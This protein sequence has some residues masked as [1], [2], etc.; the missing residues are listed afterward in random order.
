MTPENRSEQPVSK[1]IEPEVAS[2]INFHERILTAYGYTK[3]AFFP[4]DMWNIRKT[5]TEGPPLLRSKDI[6]QKLG[7]RMDYLETASY[8]PDVLSGF[9]Y[10]SEPYLLED[11]ANNQKKT[12]AEVAKKIVLDIKKELKS[13]SRKLNHF[14]TSKL[15][16]QAFTIQIDSKD[17]NF[18]IKDLKVDPN[19][20]KAEWKKLLSENEENNFESAFEVRRFGR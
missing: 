2:L 16:H 13:D 20:I 6:I 15:C 7:R 14:L 17:G 18:L 5:F 4:D 8:F 10:K 1:V 11:R 19:K 3:D 9:L 12:E